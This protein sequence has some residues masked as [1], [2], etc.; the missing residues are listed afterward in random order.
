[1]LL[2]NKCMATRLLSLLMYHSSLAF[3][4]CVRM[5]ICVQCIHKILAAG[6][7][8][9][10]QSQTVGM[11]MV[12]ANPCNHTKTDRAARQICSILSFQA[13]NVPT[14]MLRITVRDL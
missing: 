9:I 8:R 10:A 12:L 4:E 7:S 2:A 13:G 11:N 3:A 14:N 5:Y 6:M 1:V